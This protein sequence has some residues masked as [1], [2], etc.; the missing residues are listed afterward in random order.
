MLTIAVLYSFVLTNSRP[1][2]KRT[3][4]FIHLPVEGHWDF[5]F[6]VNVNKIA[7]SICEKVFCEYEFKFY[8]DQYIR[9]RFLDHTAIVCLLLLIF[10]KDNIVLLPCIKLTN[11]I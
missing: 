6:W 1:L 3:S 5:E 8:W 11:H 2:H 9:V 4:S 10:F 7:L